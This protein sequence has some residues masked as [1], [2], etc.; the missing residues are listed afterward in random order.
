MFRVL[1]IDDEIYAVK[2]IIA[3]I[4]WK[5]LDVSE[6]FEAYHAREAKA[7]L[8]SIP[9]D[10]MICDIN[11]PEENGLELLEWAKIRCPELETVF[12]TCHTDFS[13]VQKALQLGSCDYLLKPVIYEEMEEVLLKIFGRILRV[14][15]NRE[16]MES[17]KK[18]YSIE[19]K[20]KKLLENG[21][22]SDAN[23]LIEQT[24]EWSKSLNDN[25]GTLIKVHQSILQIAVYILKRKRMPLDNLNSLE[26]S[27]EGHEITCTDEQFKQWMES[28]IADV[29]TN[30]EA[31]ENK[32]Q[33]NSIVYELQIY[34]QQNLNQ[35]LTRDELAEHV[36]LNESYLSRL[37]R[38]ETGM[39]LSEYILQE[40]MKKAGELM[41]ET[42]KPI[43][44]IANQLC[45]DNFSYFSKMFK[46]VY[47]ITPQ[48]YR[49]KYYTRIYS[50][51]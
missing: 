7:I 41:S 28:I 10:L 4:D 37:F 24:L 8:E 6:I 32:L 40:R 48:E 51:K 25:G 39:S 43:Y 15:S 23:N 31:Y 49:K 19:E 46:K 16:N 26:L 33:K 35:R 36:H 47:N 42:D 18:Y 9:I 5:R 27:L 30:S 22:K 44:G 38:K 20:W 45:Y 17:F 21:D 1:V 13:Y 29:C 34:I 12:L 3:G 2:G 50:R 11:M 14:R